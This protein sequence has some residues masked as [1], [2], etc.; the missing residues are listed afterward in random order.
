MR[1]DVLVDPPVQRHRMIAPGA[2]APQQIMSGRAHIVVAAAK[3]LEP[4]DEQPLTK[5]G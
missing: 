2:P 1:R 5:S 3:R 4:L